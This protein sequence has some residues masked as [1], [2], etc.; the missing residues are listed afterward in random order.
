M[1]TQLEKCVKKFPAV[2]QDEIT[3]ELEKA[4]IV[5]LER[6]K[7]IL[8]IL[9]NA[10]EVTK[11]ETGGFNVT[12]ID[13]RDSKVMVRESDEKKFTIA[14]FISAFNWDSQYA[15][16]RPTISQVDALSPTSEQLEAIAE[17][18]LKILPH[19]KEKPEKGAIPASSLFARHKG[20]PDTADIASGKIPVNMDK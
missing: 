16:G 14:D 3:T 11:S 9:S 20:S 10:I 18:K 8:P 2:V 7:I 13:P 1:M 5:E 12:M 4:G 15:D 6:I 17:G 19:P